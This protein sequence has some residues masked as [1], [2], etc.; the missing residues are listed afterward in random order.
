MR[1]SSVYIHVPFCES[2]CPYCAFKS[3]VK[4]NGDEELYIRATAG[5]AALRSPEAG[6][7][8][9]L[10]IG[11][12]TPSALSVES[13]KTLTEAID[14]SFILADDAEITLEANPGSITE[15]HIALWSAWRV[16]RVS[17]GAQSFL[18][19]DLKFLGRIHGADQA[20]DA[21]RS[22][23]DAGFSVSLDLMFGLPRGTLRDWAS[24]LGAALALR[25]HHISVYQLSIEPGTPFAKKNFD[26]PDGYAQYRYAQWRLP[27]AGYGQYEVASFALHGNESRHNLNYW[28]DEEYIGIGPS[29]WSCRG[30]TRRMNA[31]GLDEYVKMIEDKGSAAVYE[32]RL[33]DERAARQAAVL[34]LRTSGGIDWGSFTARHGEDSA[35]EIKKELEKFPSSLI[36]R[37]ETRARLTP[38]GLRVG[39]AIWS[40]LI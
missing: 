31:P 22:C 29:A 7:L 5:E 33:D 16:N 1:T 18:D 38:K 12:G 37:S 21:V 11:G 34:A 26:L 25:P 3:A 36:E 10:Y 27:R 6:V 4:R 24:S 30:G 32:E 19:G 13:W 17:V 40:E 15:E 28:A 8:K 2:K 14:R 20:N 39:N 35:K 23:I 9:T